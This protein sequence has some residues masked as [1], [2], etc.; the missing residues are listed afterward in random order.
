MV[1][2]V[3]KKDKN[4]V[5]LE[6]EVEA[7]KFE[8]AVQKSYLKNSK[9]FTVPGFRKGKAPRS[10]IERYYG[11]EVFYED[12]I[13][14]VCADAYDKAIEENDIFPVDR[15]TISIKKIGEGENL[16][17]TA[18]VTVKPEVELGEYK[19][20]EVE[21]V[22]VNVTDEDV[23]KELKAVAE[24]NARIMSVEDRGIQK[25][26]IVDIDFEGFIDGEP[27]EGGKASG[28]VLEVGS[29]TFI[30]GFE[31]QLIGGRPG[32]DIEVNV[33]FPEDYGKKELA[34]KPAL[35]KVIVNDVKV[36]ELPAIDDEF[37]KDVSEFDTLEEYKES[38]RKKLTEAAEHRA[39]HEL[40]DKVVAKVV[41]NAQVDIP[42]VMIER[43]ID[44]MVRDYNMRLNY[45]GLDLDKYLMIMGIDYQTFRNQLRDRAHDDIKRQLVLEKVAKVEDIKV[46][47]EEINEEAEKIAKSYNM[48]HEDFKKHL[49]DDDIE[50]IKATI[51]FKKAVDFLVQNAK[52]L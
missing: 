6:I 28:Y 24:K 27:F 38:I 8:E 32:D 50:Y 26:D 33:T 18:S 16:V 40:E 15:P 4:I 10:I 12:A 31:D 43:Q 17:F 36:K 19:D 20:V 11:K 46:S 52:I 34:G 51:L 7:A 30:D 45:Q 2:K 37:A 39:K 1:V 49:R 29:G 22:E 3:E 41:E 9:K 5:E 35:F 44:S 21:K 25:G 13:N 42:D 47:D 14:I 23:E 48:E